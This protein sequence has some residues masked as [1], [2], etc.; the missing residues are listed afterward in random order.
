MIIQVE[1]GGSL[2]GDEVFIR[3]VLAPALRAAIE[4]RDITIIPRCITPC[5]A[6]VAK[7]AHVRR[8]YIDGICYAARLVR[9][10]EIEHNKAY[11]E[12]IAKHIE[13]KIKE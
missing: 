5:A 7:T 11:R 2:I 9:A 4:E 3:E 13:S 8:A 12:R 6:R 1:V 10:Y